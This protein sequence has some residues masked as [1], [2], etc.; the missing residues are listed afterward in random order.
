MK[1]RPQDLLRY[2]EQLIADNGRAALCH[3]VG[4]RMKTHWYTDAKELIAAVRELPGNLYTTL[5]APRLGV[6]GAV[7]NKDIAWITRLP[8]DF[9]PER[10]TGVC[11][12]DAELAA[13]WRVTNRVADELRRVGFPMPLWAKSGN[14]YHLQ[15]R[16]RLPNNAEVKEQFQVIY[17]GLQKEFR[18]PE[19]DIDPTVRTAH[20][21]LRAYGSVNRKGP[22]TPE[23]PHR[24][25]MV[26]IPDDWQMVTPQQIE[27]LANIYTR[28][29]PT[30]KLEPVRFDGDGDYRTLDIAAWFQAHGYYKRPIG[31][32]KHAVRCP[33]N[34]EHTVS[35]SGVD[36][37]IFDAGRGWP[38]FF[39]HHRHCDGRRIRDVLAIWGD[40]DAFCTR[41]WIP[42]SS[43]TISSS[44]H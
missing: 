9:D 29:E 32:G 21:I 31:R 17:R 8:L 18:T 28:R 27:W 11:S 37:L 30:P 36:T 7:S 13:A 39:C 10:P 3:I 6:T 15:F 12:T 42:T 4:R 22:N 20:R 44:S 35:S 19:V 43:R 1:F 14:G 2:Y 25:S 24:M 40:A 38:G 34:H 33:W 41:Q 16:C 5:N 26:W 23:R